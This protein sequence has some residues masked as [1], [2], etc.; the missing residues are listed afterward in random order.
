[1][2]LNTYYWKGY[3]AGTKIIVTL[4]LSF[5]ASNNT[6]TNTNE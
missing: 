5:V 6:D 2:K 3:V 4:L 1:M